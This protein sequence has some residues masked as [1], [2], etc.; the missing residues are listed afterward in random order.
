MRAFGE[1]TEPK[2]V[3]IRNFLAHRAMTLYESDPDW[4]SFDIHTELKGFI[5]MTIRVL[6]G[7][8]LGKAIS[9]YGF[10]RMHPS[11]AAKMLGSNR[12]H[13]IVTTRFQRTSDNETFFRF[14]Y[15]MGNKL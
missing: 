3:K 4:S 2:D 12:G 1:V 15:D 8:D 7:S 5:Q 10:V 13:L 14:S 9:Q 6:L 11:A